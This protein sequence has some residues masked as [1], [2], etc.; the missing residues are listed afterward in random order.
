M[1]KWSRKTW[2]KDVGLSVRGIVGDTA[3]MRQRG[4]YCEKKCLIAQRQLIPLTSGKDC[5]LPRLR[6]HAKIPGGTGQIMK[7]PYYEV[8]LP[9]HSLSRL[10]SSLVQQNL[11]ACDRW[12]ESWQGSTLESTSEV[13]ASAKDYFDCSSLLQDNH[14]ATIVERA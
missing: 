8:V 7:L 11:A 10:A 13:A 3:D 1:G 14:P 5:L 6:V 4:R 12:V 9:N 2:R